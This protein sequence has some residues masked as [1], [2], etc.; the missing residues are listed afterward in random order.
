MNELPEGC[1]PADADV[2]RKANHALTDENHT[3]RKQRD[4]AWAELREIREVIGADSSEATVDEVRK[5]LAH[6]KYAEAKVAHVSAKLTKLRGKLADA[7][8]HID[9]GD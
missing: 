3:L 9:T 8:I 7:N 4:V 2:L 1:T 6:L 5:L